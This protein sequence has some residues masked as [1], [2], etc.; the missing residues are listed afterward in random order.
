MTRYLGAIII[1]DTR[2][3]LRQTTNTMTNTAA[4]TA[5]EQTTYMIARAALDSAYAEIA[6]LAPMP[7]PDA[8]EPAVDAWLDASEEVRAGLGVD[9]LE[10]ALASAEDALLAWSFAVAR[11]EAGRSKRKLA[12][13]AEIERGVGEARHLRSR[14]KAID[15]ALRLAV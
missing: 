8:D 12:L 2:S 14:V 7:G 10:A 1:L 6:R 11:R 5:P 4:R 15:L 13:V 3:D 9:G